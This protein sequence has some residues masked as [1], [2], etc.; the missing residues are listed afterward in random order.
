M[1]ILNS[2]LKVSLARAKSSSVTGVTSVDV[3]VVE[4]IQSVDRSNS[5]ARLG[6]GMIT[7]RTVDS[8]GERSTPGP[9]PF[10]LEGRSLVSVARLTTEGLHLSLTC[11]RESFS[12]LAASNSIASLNLVYR[13]S[14]TLVTSSYLYEVKSIW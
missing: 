8:L 13:S 3:I 12:S 11:R 2:R 10:V 9:L 5:P 4:R 14:S 1:D 6:S 7:L